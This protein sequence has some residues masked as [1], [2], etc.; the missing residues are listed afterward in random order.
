MQVSSPLHS[1]KWV[2]L[3]TS[4][5]IRR[6]KCDESQPSCK[7]CTSTGRK[8]DGYG[9]HSDVL[10]NQALSILQRKFNNLPGT[11][12][13]KRGFSFFL[14][15]TAPELSGYFATGFWGQTIIQASIAEP[16]LRHAL[17]A[18]GSL[19]E[20]F[21][22]KKLT[23]AAH[24]HGFA[25]GQH[26]QAIGYLRKS[27][28]RGKHAPLPALMS[29]LLF[30]C[31]D[32]IRGAFSSAMLH[33]K[34]GM[35][36]IQDI[37]SKATSCSREDEYMI[38]DTIAPIFVRL[39]LQAIMY[40]DTRSTEN[41]VAFSV[42]LLMLKKE[43]THIP[44]S[45][46][47]LDATRLAL[48]QNVE[49]VFRFVL[50]CDGQKRWRD[51]PQEAIELREI[52]TRNNRLW[53]T[54]F[55]T[56]MNTHSAKLDSK[57]LRGAALLKIQHLGIKIMCDSAPTLLGDD[58]SQ[59]EVHNDPATYEKLENEFETIVKLSKSL[60]SAAELDA[61]NGKPSLSFSTDMGIIAPL[62]YTC[63]HSRS[64]STR[65]KALDL[66][67]RCPRREGM[68]DSQRS[69]QIVREFWVCE[70]RHKM[71]EQEAGEV[72]SLSELLDLEMFDGMHWQWKWKD[73]GTTG[74]STGSTPVLWEEEEVDDQIWFGGRRWPVFEE[75]GA[76][77]GG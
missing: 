76:G 45:L 5:R 33:L 6:V 43:A 10:E 56:F 54:S 38:E 20:D 64:N 48:E 11:P 17:I 62:Y 52:C 41:R 23:Y 53:N 9:F 32:S 49:E 29:C 18:L 66:L 73:P 75:F 44:E 65:A 63:T 2:A 34:S 74:M 40:M 7:R 13:E 61:K 21:T 77:T 30:V 25:M 22:N 36:I 28:A 39:S 71:L 12:D 42:C 26:T 67:S 50:M 69:A 68:W 16:S 59:Q 70:D 58:R 3:I 27:L 4:S 51:Q 47:S 15:K 14:Q 8:C 55:E 31:F 19:H 35:K 1:L 37:R 72:L 57:Q 24:D 60:I 46:Q